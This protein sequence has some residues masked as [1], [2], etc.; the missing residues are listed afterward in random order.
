M[1]TDART[2]DAER[3]RGQ[4][5]RTAERVVAERG[6][7]VSLAEIAREAGVSKSGLLHHFPS[8]DALVSGLVEHVM[9]TVWA[10]IEACREPGDEAPGAFARAYVRAMTGDSAYLT[11]LHSASGL[12]AHLGTQTGTEML[13]ERDDARRLTAAFDADGLPSGRALLVRYAAEGASLSV[14]TPYLT[15]EQRLALRAE[16]YLLTRS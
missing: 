5:L 13:E 14:N 11:E 4:I 7:G 12:L 16:L 10:E 1:S 8:R 3:T 2:R 6:I 9:E 15:E